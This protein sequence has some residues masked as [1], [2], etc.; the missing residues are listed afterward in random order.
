VIITELA[1]KLGLNVDEA[2]IAQGVAAIASL[3]TGMVAVGAAAAGIAAA[4][5]GSVHALVSYGSDVNDLSARTGVATD[6]LQRL[7]HV[8][9][10]SG[11]SFEEM[12]QSM[13]F[14]ARKGVKN[15]GAEIAKVADRVKELTEKGRGAEAAKLAMDRFGRSGARLIPFLREGSKRIAEMSDEFAELGLVIDQDTVKAADELGDRIDVASA[16][17]KGL[18]YT[19]AKPL[20]GPL[21]AVTNRFIEWMKVVR[22]FVV[23]NLPK[24]VA[25]ISKSF[26]WL[27]RLVRQVLDVVRMLLPSWDK[28]VYGVS[29]ATKTLIDLWNAMGPVAKLTAFLTAAVVFASLSWLAFAAIVALVIDDIKTWIEGGDSLLGRYFGNWKD[30]LAQFYDQ[31]GQEPGWLRFLRAGKNA[32]LDLQALWMWLKGEMTNSK[33][34]QDVLKLKPGAT[35]MDTD[36]KE[37]EGVWAGI[38]G[39]VG[40][41]PSYGGGGAPPPITIQQTLNVTQQPGSSPTDFVTKVADAS[42]RGFEDTLYEALYGVRR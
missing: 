18:A 21:T 24:A 22:K 3:R 13:N 7:G 4:L 20:L 25:A 38:M 39:A 16:S 9:S 37:G 35:P 11:I 2:G 6:Q 10:L 23:A 32:L 40:M 33:F 17:F 42:N 19:I 1:A 29:A 14:A 5:A 27:S 26:E 36:R 12:A 34:F 28:F 8:A 30:F 15:V 31:D 41:K